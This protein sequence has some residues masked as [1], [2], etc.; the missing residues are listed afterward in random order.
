MGWIEDAIGSHR[1]LWHNGEIGGFHS[2]NV[3]FPDDDLAFAILSNNQDALPEALVPGIASL[4]FPLT[5]LD[6]VVP[7][8]AVV[9]IEASLA[10]ALGA[11]AIAIVAVVT[12]R[13]WIVV[14]IVAALAALVLGLFLPV[15]IGFLGG[16]AVAL[17]PIVGY[18]VVVRF[19]RRRQEGQ[20]S[21]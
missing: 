3:I 16:G 6:R 12:L 18:V 1:Y 5:G 10:I 8:S 21:D 4:Y 7:R 11:F 15:A 20:P 19:A 14:G 9:L 17:L 13:R 2:L